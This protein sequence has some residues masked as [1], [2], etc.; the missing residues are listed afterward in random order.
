MFGRLASLVAEQG[1]QV[2]RIDQAMD[3]AASRCVQPCAPPGCAQLP[4]LA[5]P[6]P[7]VSC[8]PRS[9]EAGEGEL[10]RNLASVSSTRGLALKAVGVLVAFAVGFSV[11]AV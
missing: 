4:H 7:P 8:P 5:F 2:E 3:E 11:F 9:M 10:R 6:L 1:A